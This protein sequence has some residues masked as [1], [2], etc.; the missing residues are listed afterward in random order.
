MAFRRFSKAQETGNPAAS[1]FAAVERS[2]VVMVLAP[3][4]TFRSVNPAAEKVLGRAAADLA[5][6]GYLTILRE[7]D[8]QSDETVAMRDA[9]AAG[10]DVNR[11]APHLDHAGREIWL[12]MVATPVPG[13][14]GAL[15]EILIVAHDITA[16]HMRRRDNRGQVDAISR[17]MA[18]IEFELDGTIIDANGHFLAATGYDLAEIRG[19][20]HRMFMP[21]GEADSPAYREFWQR[22]ASGASES[23]QVK[24]LG[25]GGKV[26]WLEA[27]YETLT[28]PEG[29][30]FKVVKYA[31]DI[32]EA[33]NREADVEAKLAAIQAVQ[34]VIE[35]DATGRI[36]IANPIFCQVMGYDLEEIQGKMHGMFVS[37][38]EREGPEYKTFWER[39]RA[40]ETMSDHFLRIG[41]GGR[42]VHIE[43]SYNPIR[44]AAGQVVKVVKFAVDTTAFK[45]TLDATSSA[46]QQLAE[47]DLRTR[48]ERDLGE[49]DAI[50]AKFNEAIGKVDSVIGDVL[51]HSAELVADS[52]AIRSASDD[53]SRRTERQAATLEE[54]A[55]ALE[56]LAS[57]VKGTTASSQEARGQAQTA[58]EDTARSA[59]V[60]AV[61]MES[62]NRI[63]SSSERIS[64]ITNVI[65]D[66]SFQTNLLALNAGIEAARA[67]DAGRGFAVVASEVR[68]LAQ[69]SADA[70]REIADLISESGQQVS[71]GVRQV[72]EAEEALKQ[73]D[74]R[75]SAVVDLIVAIASSAEEQSN[76]LAEMNRAIGDLD[77]VTQQNAAMAEETNAA[78]QSFGAKVET[79]QD[80]AGYFTTTPPDGHAMNEE[81]RHPDRASA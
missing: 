20:H 27:T 61:A 31:F 39:L 74:T 16:Y 76:G 29:R 69:R 1:R 80:E 34:A 79:M 6:Q 35:F 28:D 18:V 75:M 12:D 15:Q 47:G 23:G 44:D 77:R 70:A 2:H 57:S 62:M 58:K 53:L 41:K 54:S 56:E 52:A 24:R 14:D 65:D 46:L 50:R 72:G 55:A 5:G 30:P 9:V 13:A 71:Q 38:E 64:K 66:I 32:T 43:A 68:A 19:S 51:G 78:V 7:K 10:T 59:E 45:V 17:A 40:G 42:E 22:L 8:H 49:L 81:E 11:I 73:I 37:P 60:I 36:L 3:D 67:G 25:K 33:K 48:I 4:W 63:A 26:L 21:E